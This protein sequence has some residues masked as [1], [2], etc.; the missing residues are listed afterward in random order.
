MTTEDFII[1]LFCRIDDAMKDTPKHSQSNLY[2]SEIVTLGILFALKGV[3]NRAFYRWI[4]R[5]YRKLFP[6]LPE[7]TRLFRLFATHQEWT[8]RFLVEPSLLS[9][10]DSYRMVLLSAASFRSLLAASILL[11]SALAFSNTSRITS[12]VQMYPATSSLT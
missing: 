5:D 2:P 1:E 10:I 4:T 6:K 11:L 3:G 12:V 7:R 9:V 8:D